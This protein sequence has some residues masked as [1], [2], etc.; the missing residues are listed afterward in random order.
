MKKGNNLKM[1]CAVVTAAAAAVSSLTAVS[2]DGREGLRAVRPEVSKAYSDYESGAV[3]YD[4]TSGIRPP[5]YVPSTVPETG[6]EDLPSYYKTDTTEVRDQGS[7]NTCWAFSGLGTLEAYLS[8]KGRGNYDFSEQHLSWWSTKAYN[9]DGV[10][11]LAPDLYYGGYSMM[12][13]GYLASWEGPK[14]ELDIPYNSSIGSGLPSNMDDEPTLFGTTGIMYV[15]NDMYSLKS[16]I[17]NY[18]GI[19]TSFNKG[20]DFNDDRTAYYQSEETTAYS[21][22]AVTVIGWDDNY[23]AGNFA[24]TPPGNGAWLAKNSWGPGSGDNGYLWISYYDRYIFDVDIWGV[25]LAFTSVRSLSG[26]D[27]LYQNEKYGA[28]YYTFLEDD[29]GDIL[30]SATFANVFNFDDEHSHLQNVIFETQAYGA[31]YTVWYI[32][33]K[34]LGKPDP[35]TSKWTRLADGTVD[36]TGYICA[37]VSGKIEVGGKAAVGIT[38]DSTDAGYEWAQLGVDE[39]MQNP[40]GDYIFMPKQQRNQSFVINGGNVYDLVDIYKANGDEMGGT[41][42][43]KA[44]ACSH[45]YGDADEDGAVTSADAL[46][47]LRTTV[48]LDSMDQIHLDMCDVDKDGFLTA[49]DALMILRRS[50]GLISEF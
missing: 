38:I 27:R 39:W 20:S 44:I 29:D 12:S 46:A 30:P 24:D 48:M 45:S 17:Y 49:A 50:T 31:K 42:V 2:A 4:E 23:P 22:H 10:G 3:V 19:A 8:R 25:N 32:P 33:L 43:I 26:Y 47:V 21:G 28:T 13:A 15:N 9:S 41:L 37:D 34:L 11:W 6:S 16:A 18:G 36:H 35:D 1:I 7:L 40:A 5:V 14:D